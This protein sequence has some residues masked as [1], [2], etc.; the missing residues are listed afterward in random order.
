MTKSMQVRSMPATRSPR[1]TRS[2]R[3][4]GRAP[5]IRC[6]TPSTAHQRPVERVRIPAHPLQAAGP[7]PLAPDRACDHRQR[8][9]RLARPRAGS[10]ALRG[11][12]G[13]LRP[14]P[15]R[16]SVPRLIRLDRNRRPRR[17]RPRRRS[18]RMAARV[19]N[20]GG[21]SARVGA[22]ARGWPM[23]S[24]PLPALLQGGQCCSSRPDH[25]HHAAFVGLF[26]LL[27]VQEGAVH[28]GTE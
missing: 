3:W 23:S 1:S 14:A 19:R 9:C 2:R 7:E 17:Q 4:A 10:H 21:D 24:A 22:G 15:A 28:G 20:A 25:P 6:A 26:D 12:R 13:G 27:G 11:S 18:R 8:P 5:S 16:R